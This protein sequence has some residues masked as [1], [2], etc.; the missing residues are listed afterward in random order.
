ML[1]AAFDTVL[2]AARDIIRRRLLIIG[3]GHLPTCLHRAV[4]DH[5]IVGGVLGGDVVQLLECAP[6]EVALS[7]LLQTLSI[8]IGQRTWAVLLRLAMSLVHLPCHG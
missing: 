3:Q 2:G 8:V 7:A 5:L 6:K 1:V 4:H